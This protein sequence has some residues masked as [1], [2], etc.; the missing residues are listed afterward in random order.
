MEGGLRTKCDNFTHI[1]DGQHH[2]RS[3]D[4]HSDTGQHTQ[5]RCP[6]ELVRIFECL[7]EGGYGEQSNVLLFLS[8]ANQI[9]ID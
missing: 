4:G 3:N 6:D 9:D 1:F 5:S 2:N 7:L 8:I